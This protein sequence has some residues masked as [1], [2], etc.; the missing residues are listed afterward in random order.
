MGLRSLLSRRAIWISLFS[1]V[2]ATLLALDAAPWLRAA[3]AGVGRMSPCWTR[4]VW[5]RSLWRWR[6][7]CLWPCGSVHRAVLVLC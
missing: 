2:W 6:S 4:T 3:M 7:M 1:L 5:C